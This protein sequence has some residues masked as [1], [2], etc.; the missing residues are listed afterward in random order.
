[1][2]RRNFNF[3]P[4]R[5]WSCYLKSPMHSIPYLRA[6]IEKRAPKGRPFSAMWLEQTKAFL[7]F[8][9]YILWLAWI[10]VRNN[11]I[12]GVTS[13]K[14]FVFI[15]NSFLCLKF[16]TEIITNFI[17]LECLIYWKKKF[18]YSNISFHLFCKT[19]LKTLWANGNFSTRNLSLFFIVSLV[20]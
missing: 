17:S 10:R 18:P 11:G 12:F 16:L 4:N 19:N 13:K 6:A 14:K 3:D 2:T 20:E 1:M 9:K 7:K 5:S 8:Y 15:S